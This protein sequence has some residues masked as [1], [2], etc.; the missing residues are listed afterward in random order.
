MVIGLKFRFLQSAAHFWD[1]EQFSAELLY[2]HHQKLG[3]K[4]EK[5][6]VNEYDNKSSKFS[7][8]QYI[9]YSL[10]SY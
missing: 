8:Q 1:K 6:K 10:E 5:H 4:F 9:G 3:L 2:P 7:Y